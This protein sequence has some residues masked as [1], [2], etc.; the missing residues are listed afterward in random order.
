MYL[1]GISFEKTFHINGGELI[2]IVL[3]G[4]IYF[5]VLKKNKFSCI[6]S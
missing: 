5:L 6:V 3:T 2:Y 4:N 1:N